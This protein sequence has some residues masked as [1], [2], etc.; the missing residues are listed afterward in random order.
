M[1]THRFFAA[2]ILAGAFVSAV[3][4][5][6]AQVRDARY[7]GTLICSSLPFL[8]GYLR[9]MMT[10]TVKG[11]S[12]EYTQPVVDAEKGLQIGTET[13]S[14]SIDDRAIKLSG[15]WRG[16]P[17][18]YEATYTGTFVRRAAR[19]TGRQFWTHEGKTYTRTCAGALKRPFA[20]FLKRGAANQ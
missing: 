15:G 19:L 14:G 17:Q 10:L 13:G 12:A 20:V 6:A 7:R 2:V 8:K 11:S 18:S 4:P 16:G 5:A 1:I 9:P 3:T